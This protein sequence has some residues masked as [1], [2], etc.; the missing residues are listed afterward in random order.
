MNIIRNQAFRIKIAYRSREKEEEEKI[1][2]IGRY[3]MGPT[4]KRLNT[5]Q[6]MDLLISKIVTG[7]EVKSNQLAELYKP[8][9][10][11]SK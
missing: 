2:G 11:M 8:I 10:K 1:P 9:Q 7:E 5:F 4:I 6:V 3:P